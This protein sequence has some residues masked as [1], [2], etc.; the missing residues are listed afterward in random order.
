MI[1]SEFMGKFPRGVTGYVA[2]TDTKLSAGV[3]KG[4][5][6]ALESECGFLNRSQYIESSRRQGAFADKRDLVYTLF[7]AYAKLKRAR[8]EWD[9]A[10]RY[11]CPL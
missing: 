3:I 8:Q 10:D 5:E 9:A 2:V 7:E 6:R 4:S 11:V 1:F